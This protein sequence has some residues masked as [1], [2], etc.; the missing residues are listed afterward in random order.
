MINMNIEDLKLELITLQKL[1]T[2]NALKENI[3]NKSTWLNRCLNND[4][5]E[6]AE[7]V[8]EVADRYNI[9]VLT[10]AKMFDETMLYRVL[11]RLNM[12]K[13]LNKGKI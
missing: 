9:E 2:E 10:L 7:S 8:I 1:D 11:K 5:D 12:N 6:I 4:K 13:K 3:T